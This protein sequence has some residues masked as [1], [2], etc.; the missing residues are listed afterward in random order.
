MVAFIH[1]SSGDQLPLLGI[2]CP[3]P[4]SWQWCSPQ[5]QIA[6]APYPTY[7]PHTVVEAIPIESLNLALG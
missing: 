2:C 7:H 4:Q 1:D 6:Q 5:K 3:K